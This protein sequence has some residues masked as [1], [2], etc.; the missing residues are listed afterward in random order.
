MTKCCCDGHRKRNVHN[1]N[2]LTYKS[3]DHCLVITKH[4]E[5]W[6]PC[7]GCIPIHSEKSRNDATVTIM[8]YWLDTAGWSLALCGTERL[9]TTSGRCMWPWA[10]CHCFMFMG[11]ML[12]FI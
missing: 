12:T 7:H 3:Y 4:G 1:H 6:F 2:Q 8:V 5:S 11:T 9:L 10:R